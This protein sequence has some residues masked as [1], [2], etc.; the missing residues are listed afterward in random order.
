[1]G[2]RFGFKLFYLNERAIFQIMRPCRNEE[3]FTNNIAALA[4]LI[5][6]LNTTE[7]KKV[8]G[9]KEGSMSILETFFK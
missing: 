3:E 5:D 4:L 7:M 2:D 8:V 9:E 6:Q 1:M